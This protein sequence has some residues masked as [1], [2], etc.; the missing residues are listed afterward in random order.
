MIGMWGFGVYFTLLGGI[1]ENSLEKPSRM[2]DNSSPLMLYFFFSGLSN[3]TFRLES[4]VLPYRSNGRIQRRLHSVSLSF[5][6]RQPNA[7]LLHAHN[8]SDH[9]TVSLLDSH[10]VMELRAGTDEVTLRSRSPLSDGEWHSVELRLEK[11]TLHTSS[12]VMAADGDEEKRSASATSAGELDFL[13]RGA[14]I[15]LGG[16]SLDAGATFSGCLGPVELGGLPLPFH[17]D[18][19]LKLPRPQEETFTLLNSHAAPRRG[20]WGAI[21][22]APDPCRNKG[23]CEDLFDLHRCSC[24][25]E[26]TGPLCQESTNR[27]ISGPCVHGNCTNLPGGFTCVCEPGHSGERCEVQVDVCEDSRCVNG[28]T[29]LKG[30][31]SY[32]C[33]CPQNL[34]GQYCR[35]VHPPAFSLPAGSGS[36]PQLY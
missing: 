27:C 25:S 3:V 26:W 20:C 31:Q 24:T 8:D 23:V 18:T 36:Q 11:Q 9:L 6:T 19:E 30:F 35:W 17:H 12:W 15:F 22:C 4:G 2:S 28:A 10:L 5:R 34:T 21:V 14:D 29:C 7:T 16:V 32:S 1:W 13:K 33:L